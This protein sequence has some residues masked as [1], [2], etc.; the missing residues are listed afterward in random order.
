MDFKLEKLLEELKSIK[1]TNTTPEPSF[2]DIS[3][4]PHYENV[5]SNILKFFVMSKEL[6]GL[7]DLFIQALLNS[8]GE[9]VNHEIEVYEVIRE[10]AT[11]K[12]NRLDLVILTREYVI[13]I[14]NKIF[15]GLYNDLDDYSNYLNGIK[16][17]R[18][19]FKVILSIYPS[20]S[21]NSGFINIRYS[22]FFSS[23]DL[24]I[25]NYWHTGRE[26]Y[27]TYLKDFMQTIRRIE[28]GIKMDNELEEFIVKNLD[29]VERLYKAC[30]QFKK[31]LRQMVQDL[32]EMVSVDDKIYTRWFYR[33]N[34]DLEDDLVHD[35]KVGEAVVSV[36]AFTS[37]SDWTI[38]IWLRK[39]ETRNLAN[40]QTL[41]DWLISKGISGVDIMVKE[42]DRI[43]FLKKYITTNETAIALQ[44]I[45]DKLCK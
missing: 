16:G 31:K 12:G 25:G 39:P 18:S 44:E 1:A 15:A 37:G 42:Q 19:L 28:G 7:N 26:K 38:S 33:E 34:D 40:N 2:M 13:G 20:Q 6:H 21:S 8:L 5:C 9:I 3:G 30:N 11:N 36:D 14:E 35:I 10:Q 32:G 43:V 29:E 24:L 4:F 17:G 41:A 23:I 22:D 45:L 27:L